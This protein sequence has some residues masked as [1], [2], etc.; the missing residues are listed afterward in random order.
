MNELLQMSLVD[1]T[2]A[3]H[4]KKVSPVELLTLSAWL[5]DKKASRHDLGQMLAEVGQTLQKE[6]KQ[7]ADGQKK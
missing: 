6:S 2:Q 4:A 3:L 7:A 1:L 5:D